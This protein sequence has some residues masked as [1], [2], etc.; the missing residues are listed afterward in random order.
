MIA[1]LS[2]FPARN[3]L[4]G[5]LL[6]AVLLAGITLAPVAIQTT[7]AETGS[8]GTIQ[9]LVNYCQRHAP[10]K[11]DS[12]CGDNSTISGVR[13]AAEQTKKCSNL[14]SD[15][16]LASC[17]L[18][19][20]ERIISQALQGAKT[21][22]DFKSNLQQ[23]YTHEHLDPS[24]QTAT[25]GQNQSDQ[26]TDGATFSTGDYKGTLRDTC[27]GIV[28]GKDLSVKTSIN[29]GCKGKGN[30][31]ADAIFA[32][33]RIL[34]DG[35]GIVIVGSLVYGGIQYSGSRGDPQSVALAVNRLRST[36]FALLIFIFGYA[37]LNYI[38]PAGFLGQ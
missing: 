6:L 9:E 11:I 2:A 27:G 3:A 31:I 29:I 22:D 32:I 33:I 1:S 24:Q 18:S 10:S 34:S 25:A 7:S 26:T 38:I 20:G 13:N 28:D 23:I 35:V 17:I 16:G 21:G 14:S 36:V 4:R 15:T 8:G 37:F 30:P 5:V 12:T 19:E